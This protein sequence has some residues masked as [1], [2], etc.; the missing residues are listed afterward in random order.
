MRESL[1]PGE[2]LHAAIWASRPDSHT[3]VGMTRAD[4]S[5][6]R[7]RLRGGDG[8]RRGLNGKPRSHAVE[9]DEHMRTVTDPRVLALTDRRLVVL[10]RRRGAL[11]L[12]WECPRDGLK[13]VSERDGRLR[14]DFADGSSVSLLT[15]SAQAQPFVGAVSG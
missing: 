2:T 8:V 13:E 10:A 7:F 11:R 15:P 6:F 5:P 12:R 3:S 1:D 9:L 4:M 14:L